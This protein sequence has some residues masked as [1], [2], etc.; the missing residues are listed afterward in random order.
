MLGGFFVLGISAWHLARGRE[1]EFFTRCVR[2]AAPFTL[3][4]AILTGYAGHHQGQ[5]VAILQPAKM[6]AMESHWNTQANAP[7]N[8]LVW[9]DQEN[10]RNRIEALPVPGLM[11]F[12]AFNDSAAE[13]KGLSDF[14]KEDIPPVLP[15][16]LSF[17]F[18]AGMGCLFIFIAGWAFLRRRDLSS[19]PLLMK[20]L[21]LLIPLPYLTIMAGWTVAE[22]GRQP[23]IVYGLMRTADAASPVPVSSVVISIAAFLA[24]YSLLGA[25][26]IWLL[27]KNARKG[28]E[29][30]AGAQED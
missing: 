8:I 25:I 13:V 18:M 2:I 14:A 21:P 6:A 27:C 20:L 16:F 24:V 5:N 17:R 12:I 11:S 3:A 4:A 15:V 23:W 22:V 26:D 30:A 19:S 7:M 29:P 28:P 1:K 10:S 9:P